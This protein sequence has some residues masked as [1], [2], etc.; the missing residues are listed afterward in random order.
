MYTLTARQ[1]QEE[2]EMRELDR[3]AAELDQA[4]KLLQEKSY[5]T[6]LTARDFSENMITRQRLDEQV[7]RW[8][9]A[10]QAYQRAW[11]T[12][13]TAAKAAGEMD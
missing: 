3:L 7:A 12:Y 8:L 9:E 11:E 6:A 10:Q 1:Q 5:A 13:S 2:A 4:H